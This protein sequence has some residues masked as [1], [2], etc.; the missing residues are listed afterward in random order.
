MT[1]KP[2]SKKCR[3]T[4]LSDELKVSRVDS[5][6]LIQEIKETQAVYYEGIQLN[7]KAKIQSS[8][9]LDSAEYVLRY[10]FNRIMNKLKKRLVQSYGIKTLDKVSMDNQSSFLN[11]YSAS[12]QH[13]LE[14]PLDEQAREDSSEAKED[15]LYLKQSNKEDFEGFKAKQQTS[16]EALSELNSNLSTKFSKFTKE[17]SLKDVALLLLELEDELSSLDTNAQSEESTP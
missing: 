15:F 9:I 13:F 5:K 6:L 14:H 1:E 3:I 11:K 7:E 2:H 17:V 12:F 10:S 16:F 4:K 8:L